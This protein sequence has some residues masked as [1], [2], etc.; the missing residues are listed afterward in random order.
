MEAHAN[1]ASVPYFLAIEIYK[2]QK[3]WIK[4]AEMLDEA[5]RRNPQQKL[6]T[7]KPL[8]NPEDITKENVKESIA[9]TI[10]EA[11]KAYRKELWVNLFNKALTLS[12]KGNIEESMELFNVA[13]N[14]NPLEI[15]TYIVL[16]KFHKD[17]GNLERALELINSGLNLENMN[18]EEKTELWLEK[19][20]I[21]KEQKDYDSAMV[22]Y[23]Q[24]YDD[25]NNTLSIINMLQI[26]LIT[27]N[28]LEAMEWGDIAMKTPEIR[29]E[30][31]MFGLIL[32]NIGLAY[33][34]YGQVHYDQG[35]DI[36]NGENNL[37]LAAKT[38]AINHYKLA[39]NNFSTARDYFLDAEVEEVEDGATQAK[40]MKNIIK[41]IK[42]SYIPDLE[43]QSPLN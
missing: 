33:M 29:M 24:V 3:N 38:D 21:Y 27:K 37:T 22:I 42:D 32:Y 39:M 20:E 9:Y 40:S 28:Y 19:A 18:P 34:Y 13:L 16:T 6:E 12:Q 17:S 15:Q 8:I 5:I 30:R 11:V 35:T 41:L 4:M 25:D 7:P 14:V 2:P 23:K 36:Y 1:D 31:S 10:E 43:K 26:N